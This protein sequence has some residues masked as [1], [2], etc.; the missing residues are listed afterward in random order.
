[1]F[2]SGFVSAFSMCVCVL[3]VSL[4]NVFV[5]VCVRVCGGI[6]CDCESGVAIVELVVDEMWI[7]VRLVGSLSMY[8]FSVM[9]VLG[10]GEQ[11]RTQTKDVYT[12]N[13]E[14]VW[15]HRRTS[16]HVHE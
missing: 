8:Q 5:F 15:L 6:R 9:C 7:S 16:K 1:M 14:T 11:I 4:M 12:E 2:D 3:F 10:F 13:P